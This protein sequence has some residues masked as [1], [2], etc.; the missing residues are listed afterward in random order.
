[1]SILGFLGDVLRIFQVYLDYKQ[2]KGEAAYQKWLQDGIDQTK[3]LMEAQSDEERAK[4]LH[5]I[6]NRQHNIP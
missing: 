2:A 5:D 1:M 3:Q 6:V 4:L